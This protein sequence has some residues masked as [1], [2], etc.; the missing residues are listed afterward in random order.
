VGKSN[1]AFQKILEMSRAVNGVKRV[2]LREK[3]FIFG[4]GSRPNGINS[5]P[6]A[7]LLKN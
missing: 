7:C 6:L 5:N 3:Q 1:S 2:F 4:C